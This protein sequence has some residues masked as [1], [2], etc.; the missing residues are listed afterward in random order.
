[1]RESTVNVH[2][3]GGRNSQNSS[4]MDQDRDQDQDKEKTK[5]PLAFFNSED[6]M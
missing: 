5:M 2:D 3:V 6:Q 1:M 4:M